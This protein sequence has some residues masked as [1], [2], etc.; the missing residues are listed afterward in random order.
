MSH[1]LVFSIFKQQLLLVMW[2]KDEKVI[3][4]SLGLLNFYEIFNLFLI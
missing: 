2:E 3:A 4:F 1:D